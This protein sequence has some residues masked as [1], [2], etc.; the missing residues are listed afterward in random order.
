MACNLAEN[1]YQFIVDG[2]ENEKFTGIE[3][4]CDV[5]WEKWLSS[6]FS[7]DFGVPSFPERYIPTEHFR[8]NVSALQH[9][10]AHQ[11]I[12]N[13][14]NQIF[15]EPFF[16][17]TEDKKTIRT[18]VHKFESD[19]KGQQN[20][21]EHCIE[22]KGLLTEKSI[23]VLSGFKYNDENIAFIKSL[24]RF[25]HLDLNER[26]EVDICVFANG[27]LIAVELK[28][29]SDST[30]A[31]IQLEKFKTLMQK[32]LPDVNLHLILMTIYQ[33][34]KSES[35]FTMKDCNITKENQI[36][37]SPSKWTG[38][39]LFWNRLNLRTIYSK[40]LFELQK[41]FTGLTAIERIQ[42]VSSFS[43]EFEINQQ[44]C[45]K[46]SSSQTDL[47]Q[48]EII[49]RILQ[50]HHFIGKSRPG[51]ERTTEKFR[52]ILNIFSLT[53]A[54]RTILESENNLHVL[55]NG[56][57]GTGKTVLLMFKALE[58]VQNNQTVLIICPKIAEPVFLPVTKMGVQIYSISLII[59]GKLQPIPKADYYLIDDFHAPG[60]Q[61]L[62]SEHF[63]V[64]KKHEKPK[65]KDDF[66][67]S[68]IWL[69]VDVM[70]DAFASKFNTPRESLYEEEMGTLDLQENPLLCPILSDE[71]QIFNLCLILR[72]SSSIS[73]IIKELYYLA[74]EDVDNSL[75]SKFILKIECGHC[76]QGQIDYAT[77]EKESEIQERVREKLNELIPKYNSDIAVIVPIDRENFQEFFES[78]IN[79]NL[80][81]TTLE[82]FAP[83]PPV[84]SREWKAGIVVLTSG[85][86]A[87][88]P[89][90]VVLT[91]LS[92]AI[93]RIRT[94]MTLI[95]SRA[96][97]KELATWFQTCP[98]ELE[99]FLK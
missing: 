91:S 53:S 67:K 20:E 58:I 4:A 5:F 13:A 11:Y 40:E 76:V 92:L 78:F 47:P 55:L 41:L 98:N 50:S 74:K 27:T 71:F 46:L 66:R 65:I 86:V 48:L 82:D 34:N 10:Q 45:Y 36:W 32:L 80:N 23:F 6:K 18:S 43:N 54:Q 28:S 2:H 89:F 62:V 12:T 70:Q 79:N 90:L 52:E 85:C 81:L 8:A 49:D 64:Q 26:G 73:N 99:N 69:V 31:K 75:I 37:S 94:H 33:G 59:N 77:V 1:K 25:S 87:V 38:W 83:T 96:T 24:P 44:I 51:I 29:N 9:N 17:G 16:K 39:K 63:F 72:N 7:S 42:N 84:F 30:Y 68:I 88:G 21:M 97:L 15:T 3:Q 93:S 19:V 14:G 95:A 35:V 61:D 57:P 56:G 60:V 22:L